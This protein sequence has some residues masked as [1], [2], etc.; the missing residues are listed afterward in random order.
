MSQPEEIAAMTETIESGD[1]YFF[2]RSRVEVAEPSSLE[3][4]Q[5][6]QLVMIADGAS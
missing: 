2:Y 1:I 6:F 4:I 3:D 5:T